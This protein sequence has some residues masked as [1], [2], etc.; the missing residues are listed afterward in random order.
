MGG[1][2]NRINQIHKLRSLFHFFSKKELKKF[3]TQRKTSSFLLG[4][5]YLLFSWTSAIFDVLVQNLSNCLKNILILLSFRTTN[6]SEGLKQ[7]MHNFKL[8]ILIVI[9]SCFFKCQ[10]PQSRLSRDLWSVRMNLIMNF[11]AYNMQY[12]YND[13]FHL[14]QFFSMPKV[15]ENLLNE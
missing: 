10:E 6:L 3:Y 4:F 2:I 8:Y 9:L 15:N 5:N 1:K 13:L 7:A 11:E 14:L 12:I